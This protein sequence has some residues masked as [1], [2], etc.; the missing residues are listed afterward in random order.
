MICAETTKNEFVNQK[1]QTLSAAD[2]S[3]KGSIDVHILEL[4][5]LINDNDDCFTTSSCS[6]RTVVYY[7]VKS[8]IYM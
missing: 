3:K 7:K 4:V 2:F 1:K 5:N 8:S 6:G